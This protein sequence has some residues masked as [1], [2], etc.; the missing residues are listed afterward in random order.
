M[1]DRVFPG[2]SSFRSLATGLLGAAAMA[3]LVFCTVDLRWGR[4]Q[5]EVP[6]KGIEVMFVL[7]VS[8]SMLAEDV[9]PNRLQ[10]AKQMSEDATKPLEAELGKL[11]SNLLNM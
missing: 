10:R 3:L 5:R 9:T 11:D 2:R 4:V 8:R 6:Q 1:I 7:D